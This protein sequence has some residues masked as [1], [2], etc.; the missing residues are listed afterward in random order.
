MTVNHEVA[1]ELV[2]RAPNRCRPHKACNSLLIGYAIVLAVVLWRLDT[3]WAHLSVVIHAVDLTVFAL[4]MFF[5]KGP[6]SPFFVYFIFSLVCA[7][8]RWQWRGKMYTAAIAL[9][10]VM[11]MAVYPVNLLSDPEFEIDRF[12]IRIGYLPFVAILL[13]YMGAY[14]RQ[15]RQTAATEER[16]SLAHDLH[17]G[18]LESLTGAALQNWKRC[19]KDSKEG[20]TNGFRE[21]GNE[22]DACIYISKGVD[23]YISRYIVL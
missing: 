4:L 14:K 20:K 6:A 13:G 5:T 2:Q 18:L 15:L 21:T 1:G 19:A 9:G 8:L 10:I 22:D 7:T 23:K 3:T 12:I 17:D 16:I 11:V